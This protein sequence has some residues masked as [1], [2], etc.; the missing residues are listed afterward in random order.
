M[1]K[2]SLVKTRPATGTL[3]QACV[4]ACWLAALALL[5]AAQAREPTRQTSIGLFYLP[6]ATDRKVLW[7]EGDDGEKL[8]LQGRVLDTLGTPIEGALVELWHADAVGSVDESRFRTAQVSNKRGRFGIATVLPGHI[9]MARDNAVFGPRH[10]HVVVSHPNFRQLVSLIFFKG[11]ERLYNTPYPDL[12]VPLEQ[13]RSG[14][15]QVWFARVELVLA[16]L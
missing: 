7:R 9:E 4:L 15:K 10:I 11:D 8:T 16:P 3:A 12:A 5:S 6:G 2:H 1:A 13:A 14:N